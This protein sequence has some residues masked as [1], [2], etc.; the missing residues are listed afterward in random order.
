MAGVKAI[1]IL[2][3]LLLLAGVSLITQRLELLSGLLALLII[4]QPEIRRA[5]IRL[6]HSRLF[7]GFLQAGPGERNQAIENVTKAAESLAAKRIGALMVIERTT[8]LSHYAELGVPLDGLISADLLGSLFL[9]Y[10]PLQG[11]SVPGPSFFESV[12]RRWWVKEKA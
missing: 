6:G 3:G 11:E 2:A 12:I 10:S 8:S 9:P 4:F 1:T 7:Q 5:L